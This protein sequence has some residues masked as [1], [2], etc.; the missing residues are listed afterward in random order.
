M[1]D[2]KVVAVTSRRSFLGMLGISSLA[3]YA[4]APAARADAATT[5]EKLGPALG[6]KKATPVSNKFII[7]NEGTKP[8]SVNYRRYVDGE[9]QRSDGRT[10]YRYLVSSVLLPGEELCITAA[11]MKGPY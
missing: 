5:L 7:R 11:E 4:E 8:M 9:D 10:G 6:I 3:L 1:A 2:A